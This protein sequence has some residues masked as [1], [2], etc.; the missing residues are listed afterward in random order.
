MTESLDL[1]F[2][3]VKQPIFKNED[4][5]TERKVIIEEL[6][7]MMDEPESFAGTNLNELM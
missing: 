5:S 1:L 6:K 4:I 7:G 2:D 3:M